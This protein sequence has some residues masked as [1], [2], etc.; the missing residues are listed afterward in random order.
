MRWDSVRGLIPQ[1]DLSNSQNLFGPEARS[2]RISAVHLLPSMLAA[3][4][5]QPFFFSSCFDEDIRPLYK[6]LQSI[7]LYLYCITTQSIAKGEQF[8]KIHVIVGSNRP[9]RATDRLAKWV[10]EQGNSAAGAHFEL[11]DLKSYDLP[12]FNEQIS[13]QYN[14]QR[15]PEGDVKRWLEKLAEADGYVIVTPEYNRS[16]PAVL[17]N[18]LDYIDF[19]IQQKPVALVAHGSTGGAQA[20]AHLRGVIPGLQSVTTPKATYISARVSDAFD[21]AGKAQNL[22]NHF[23]DSLKATLEE[24]LWYTQALASARQ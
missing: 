10:V 2:R 15:Q 3:L 14:S 13:P 7:V 5:M 6:T 12:M 17:K 9:Q 24:L 20:V 21:E 16:F 4:A 11:L 1:S 8:M 22:D 18:A 23:A 19:Q